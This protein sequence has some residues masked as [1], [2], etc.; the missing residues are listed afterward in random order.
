MPLSD[1]DHYRIKRYDMIYPL[2]VLRLLKTSLIYENKDE[3]ID[4][5]K[6]N[7]V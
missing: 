2:F 4:N 3:K 7:T 6:D 5:E 1:L